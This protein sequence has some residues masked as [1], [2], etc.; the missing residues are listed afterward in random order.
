MAP[1]G[2]DRSKVFGIIGICLCWCFLGGL[3]FSILSI[4]Q[5]SKYGSP[6]TLGIVGLALTIVLQ[7]VWYVALNN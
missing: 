7:V 3:I 6:K 1:A 4:T 5:A 2:N